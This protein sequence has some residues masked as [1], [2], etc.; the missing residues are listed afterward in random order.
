MVFTCPRDAGAHIGGIA[1]LCRAY[2]EAKDMFASCGVLLDY[3]DYHYPHTHWLDRIPGTKCQNLRY[4]W[5]Q[6]RHLESLLA[7]GGYGVVHIHTSRRFLFAKDMWLIHRLRAHYTGKVFVTIHVGDIRTVFASTAVRDL[8]I[9]QINRDVDKVLF[10]SER[11]RRSFV[12]AGLEESRSETLYNFCDV[13]R[14]APRL[15]EGV[16]RMLYLGSINADK[17][18]R[19]LMEATRHTLRPFHLDVCGTV[20]DEALR[21]DFNRWVAQLSDRVTY[22]G[23]AGREKKQE[24]LAK[25]DILVLPSYREGFPVSILE[26]M[27]S[28]CG[29]IATPVGANPEILNQ[30]NAEIVP[31]ADA[32]ALRDAIDRLLADPER[33][34]AMKLANHRAADRFSKQ[35]NIESLCRLYKA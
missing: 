3:D 10:L 29:V 1:T 12:E 13:P 5:K 20:I 15:M 2:E 33:L 6:Y 19:E 17:G 26:A 23:Y 16:P 35:V 30:A 8:L 22:H 11:M 32:P 27:Y 4:A 9:R 34:Q 24:M 18:I 7:C 28:G 21:P 31:V 25:A 14:L